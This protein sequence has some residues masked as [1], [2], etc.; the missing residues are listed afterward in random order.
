M[1][2]TEFLE[3][4]KEKRI[5]LP[6]LKKNTHELSRIKRVIG[7][8]SGKGGVGKSLVA[9]LLSVL[10]QRKGYNTALLDADITGPSI[11]KMFGL[12]G[13]LEKDKDGMCPRI[14]ETGIKIMSANFLLKDETD[15]IMWRGPIIS[16]IIR[17]FWRDVIWGDIDVMFIDF[18]PGTGDVPLTVF[19]NVDLDGIIVVT[20]PQELVSMIVKKAIKMANNLNVPVLGVV[21]NMSYV[22]CPKCG[23]I[24]NMFEGN[25]TKNI[26]R[27]YDIPILGK[28]PVSPEFAKACDNGK[29][30]SVNASC[31]DVCLE[32]LGL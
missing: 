6:E 31:L 28:M 3:I 5:I 8:C 22:K 10:S 18:P 9:A 27:Q 15:P 21:E 32:I 7:V 2:T 4:K 24:I 12:K 26:S 29:V 13:G 1:V 20:S 19:Q 11:P 16:D 30:E 17:Q 25:S 14:S 23:E